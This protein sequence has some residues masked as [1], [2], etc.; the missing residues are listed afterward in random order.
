MNGRIGGQR[1]GPRVALLG[2]F[3]ANDV[4]HF[5]RM[6]PTI[7]QN[8]SIWEMGG[9]VDIRELDLIVLASDVEETDDR[10]Q[11]THVV[12]FSKH[13]SRLPG[14]VLTV[15]FIYLIMLK[16]RNSCFPMFPYHSAV[17][18]MQTIVT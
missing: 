1:P 9:L 6:F 15:T 3:E 13:I 17:V 11:K 2:N 5:Q 4:E 7:W 14:P 16:L 8:E 12:C 18:A 10:P